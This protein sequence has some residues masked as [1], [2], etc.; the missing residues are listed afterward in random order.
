MVIDGQI[1]VWDEGMEEHAAQ[2]LHRT[3]SCDDVLLAM[4]EAGVDAAIVVPPGRH[5]NE[6]SLAIA[7]AHPDRF[8]VMAVLAL[9]KEEGRRAVAEWADRPRELL[10]VRFS[11]PP[12]RPTSWMTDG[13]A[14]WFWPAAEAQRLPVMI[15]APGQWDAFF[16][17]AAR[18][19]GLPF[20]VDHFGLYVD[21]LD[22][23]VTPALDAVLALAALP[24]VAVKASALPCH[25]SHPYPFRNLHADIRRVFDAFGPQRMFWGSD[26]T[27]LPCPYRQAVTMFTEELDFLSADDLDWIM[28]RGLATWLDWPG[29]R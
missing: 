6:F 15:W 5:Q 17:I 11:F 24:N 16:E 2:I 27:R 8:G 20:I 23:A 1:H 25:S 29:H 9:D 4:D 3:M 12:W 7:A 21:V 28:G 10:G 22:D 14:D 26:L 19:P 13:T 18:H